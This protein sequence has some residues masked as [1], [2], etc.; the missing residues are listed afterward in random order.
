MVMRSPI[1]P[2]IRE[3]LSN[4]TYMKDCVIAIGCS[5]RVQWHHGY[6]YAGKRTNEL[7]TIIPLCEYHHSKAGT[8][9]VD[10]IVNMNI[11]ARIAHFKAFDDFAAKYPRQTLFPKSS[12]SVI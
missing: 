3:E 8:P 9:H 11:R 10:T 12:P 6:R 5:G 7:Y 2:A 1:P 4:D